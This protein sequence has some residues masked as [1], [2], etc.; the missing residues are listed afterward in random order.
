MGEQNKIFKYMFMSIKRK[1]VLCERSLGKK[2]Q[3]R[4]T[5]FGI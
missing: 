4:I 3:K 2:V 5:P 1:D